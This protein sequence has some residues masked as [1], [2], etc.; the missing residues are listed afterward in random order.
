MFQQSTEKLT[1]RLCTIYKY[2]FLMPRSPVRFQCPYPCPTCSPACQGWNEGMSLPR[3]GFSG[4]RA[5]GMWSLW[6][7][8]LVDSS[9]GGSGGQCQQL[10][11]KVGRPGPGMVPARAKEEEQGP[12]VVVQTSGL[13]TWARQELWSAVASGMRALP[14]WLL[15]TPGRVCAVLREC[16]RDL[17][18]EVSHGATCRLPP[19]WGSS[20]CSWGHLETGTKRCTHGAG[21]SLEPA[22]SERPRHSTQALTS[23]PATSMHETG[24]CGLSP[25]SAGGSGSRFPVGSTRAAWASRGS[26]ASMP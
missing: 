13:G 17:C 14:L 24:T 18:P 20:F 5:S 6:V 21:A 8:E 11:D 26:S 19:S 3:P 23:L 7:P 10:D 22:V 2:L 9:Q 1:I 15:L 12:C 16:L 4:G 25:H